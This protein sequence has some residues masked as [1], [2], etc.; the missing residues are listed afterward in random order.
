MN[1]EWFSKQ[2]QRSS[3]LLYYF[4]FSCLYHVATNDIPNRTSGRSLLTFR[5]SNGLSDVEGRWEVKNFHAADGAIIWV[6]KITVK[7]STRSSYSRCIGFESW[8]VYHLF[9]RLSWV[10]WGISPKWLGTSLTVYSVVV[11][12]CN[13]MFSNNPASCPTF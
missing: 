5:Q 10:S 7:W 11:D 2:Q 6:R 3:F 4:G 8:P 13:T 9:R 12:M 1:N